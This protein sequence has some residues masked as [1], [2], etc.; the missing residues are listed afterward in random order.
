MS[1]ADRITFSLPHRV[2]LAIEHER[3]ERGVSRSAFIVA[4]LQRVLANEDEEYNESVKEKLW[5]QGY[6]QCPRTDQ[7][8]ALGQFSLALLTKRYV[9][10]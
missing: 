8:A 7:E 1:K 3:K 2:K 9:A 4:A 10:V 5:I 6:Q